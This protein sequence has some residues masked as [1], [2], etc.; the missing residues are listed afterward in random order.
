MLPMLD[1]GRDYPA[2]SPSPVVGENLIVM[3]DGSHMFGN[4]D[5]KKPTR[6]TDNG[7]YTIGPDQ[8]YVRKGHLIPPEAE[9]VIYQE[10][11]EPV[12]TEEFVSD[13]IAKPSARKSRSKVETTSE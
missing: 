13:R 12:A 7:V 8:F 4:N 5:E 1:L 2:P 10:A 3:E 11:E 9:N 6:A